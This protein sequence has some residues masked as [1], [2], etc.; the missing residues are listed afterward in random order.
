M[1]TTRNR[2][3]GWPALTVGV[4]CL[5]LGL[6]AADLRAA[7]ATNRPARVDFSTF[8]II[9]DRNVF[10]ASRS[11]ARPS[12]STTPRETPRPRR[13]ES[14]ALVGTLESDAGAVAF[15]DGSSSE[16]RKAL[17]PEATIA[18]HKIA[19]ISNKG[20]QLENGDKKLEL[21]VGMQMRREDEGEWQMTAFTG[22]FDSGGGSRDS[23]R[24]RGGRDWGRRDS[25]RSSSD[26]DYG[27]SSSSG[28]SSSTASSAE[29]SDVLKRLMEQREKENR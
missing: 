1:S 23:E 5:L 15:F 11:G 14:F 21:P 27:R 4:G 2:F 17:K 3:P 7:G 12:F 8:K 13:I 24:D 6:A 16:F 20:V 22:G 28:G 29:V 18:G 25:G 10:N 19:G 26:R 9:T